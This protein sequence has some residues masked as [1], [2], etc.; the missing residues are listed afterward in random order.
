MRGMM[1]NSSW[2]KFF[3]IPM[4]SFKPIMEVILYHIL[5]NY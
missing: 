2:K 4:N 3:L 5:L 1:C